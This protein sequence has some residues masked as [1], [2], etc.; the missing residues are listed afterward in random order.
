MNDDLLSTD[1]NSISIQL[2]DDPRI[3][4]LPNILKCLCYTYVTNLK[5]WIRLA[6]KRQAMTDVTN[7]YN[8]PNITSGVMFNHMVV[9][10]QFSG[11]PSEIELTDFEFENICNI[12]VQTAHSDNRLHNIIK[13]CK[14]NVE[15]AWELC[16]HFIIPIRLM[17]STIP[18][19][20]RIISLRKWFNIVFVLPFITKYVQ[21]YN[22]LI[23]DS[24]KLLDFYKQFQNFYENDQDKIERF[25]KISFNDISTVFISTMACRNPPQ[26]FI[27]LSMIMLIIGS[28]DIIKHYCPNYNACHSIN[29]KFDG[30]W[31]NIYDPYHAEHIKHINDLL[32]LTKV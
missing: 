18:R 15:A 8:K 10:G 31:V 5:V 19:D 11:T 29:P 22:Q 21:Q 14:E 17:A 7:L 25:A 2:K 26:V 23:K 13:N 4:L 16:Y 1:F 32:S 6:L 28:I 3:I 9:S 20:V 30:T 27:R 12:L 24:A